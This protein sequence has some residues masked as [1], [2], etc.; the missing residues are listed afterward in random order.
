MPVVPLVQVTQI[1]HQVVQPQGGPL[2]YGGGLRRLVVSVGQAGQILVFLGEIRQLGD[3]VD[4][5]PADELQGLGHD[6]HISVIAHIARGSPKVDDPLG[7]RALL[8]VGVHVG[9]DVMA[10]LLLPGL[11][12]VVVDVLCMGLQL[13]DLFLGDVQAQ[14]LLG[15]GQSDPEP[16][17]RP[18]LVIRG[19]QELHVLAR[20]SLRQRAGIFAGVWHVS[21]S[22][23]RARTKPSVP[24]PSGSKLTKKL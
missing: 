7:G 23:I 12:D 6:D 3:G 24:V 17:P 13:I 21:S 16:A 19:E 11:G 22:L 4:Q 1:H 8:S 14:F 15:F 9:H 2:A 10:D 18:E 5:L 20:I